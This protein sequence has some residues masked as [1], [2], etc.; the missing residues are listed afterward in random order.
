MGKR[1]SIED[2]GDYDNSPEV[3]LSAE[4]LMVYIDGSPANDR[5]TTIQNS[6]IPLRAA[7]DISN[8]EE[9]SDFR[10]SVVNFL[11]EK[12]FGAFPEIPAP[13]EPRLVFHSADMGPYGNHIYSFIPEE[14]W[15]LKIDIRWRNDPEVDNPL[16][17]VLR[18]Q[19]ENRFESENFIEG[20]EEEW[21]IA[22]LEVRGVGET[23]WSPDLQWH[24]RRASAWT[25]R[26]IA[27]MQVYDL[28]RC[29]EFCRTLKGVNADK[30]GLAARDEMGV[31]ALY[32]ALLN[33]NCH[34]VILK[35]PPESQD[36][37]SQPDGR[38][39]AIEMLNCLKI[40]D[41]Y[42]LPALIPSTNI[43]FKGIIP[44]AYQWSEKILKNIGKGGFTRIDK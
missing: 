32:A 6:F 26:T 37:A 7:P 31:V 21:N 8:E 16:M 28:L 38:G 27:S 22:Y 11:I 44:E 42:Q 24:I 9:L 35:N 3:L 12:T 18:N 10:N 25:G 43:I 39:A 36:I 1:I 33:G 5:T 34:T 29:L 40:T 14:G 19:N 4:E 20:L 41:V 23:G 15:R 13:L 30:I 17:I 2:I